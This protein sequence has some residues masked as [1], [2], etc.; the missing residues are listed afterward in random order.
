MKKIFLSAALV[1]ALFGANAQGL[2]V[3][4]NAGLYTTWLM[5]KNVFDQDEI[6]NPSFSG[7]PAFGFVG[8]FYF[9]KT[10]GVSAELNFATVRQNYSG[11]YSPNNTYESK[12]TLKYTQIPL[13]FKL[14]S[15]GGFYFEVGPQ[16]SFLGKATEDYTDDQNSDNDYTDLDVKQ[17]FTEAPISFVFG[18]GGKFDLSDHL[19]L[20]AGLR[21]A[22]SL[23]DIT[24]EYTQQEAADIVL[25]SDKG[26][27]GAL[28]IT[29]AYAHLTQSGSFKYQKTTLA[30][31]GIQMSL[32]YKLGGSK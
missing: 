26:E 25:N 14:Q 12:T 10:I 11:E 6:L 22:G 18:F 23:S 4:V 7:G 13:L 15:E 19:A 9:S 2:E 27:F 16:F 32:V 28:G 21:L 30:V 8:S 31:A 20:T 29:D 24:Q 1:V 17:G 5:N 3:G